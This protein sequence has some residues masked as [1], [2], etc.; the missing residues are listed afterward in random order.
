[1]EITLLY[2]DGCPNWRR[3]DQQLRGL[4]ASGQLS[5]ELRHRL[6]ETPEDAVRLGFPGSPTVLVDGAD[7]FAT[8]DERP[9]LACR[10]YHTEHGPQGGPTLDQLRRALLG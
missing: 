5:A 9:G 1:M 2:F 4:I 6:V 3:T 10:V 7:P 8:G